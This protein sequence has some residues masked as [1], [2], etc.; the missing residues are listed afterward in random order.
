MLKVGKYYF[1]WILVILVLAAC[2]AQLYNK[3]DPSPTNF[4]MSKE[5]A[6][7]HKNSLEWWY[8]TG[9]LADSSQGKTFGME[10]VLFHFSPTRFKSY[11]MVNLAL[12]DPESPAFYY[13]H[14]L[15]PLKKKWKSHYPLNIGFD[16]LDFNLKGAEG[17][18]KLRAE[19][20]DHIVQYNLETSPSKDLLFH[21]STAYLHYGDVAVAGYFTYPRLSTKGTIILKNE[22][23]Q[24]KGDLWFDRQWN[25]NEVTD[26]R[27]AWDWFSVQFDQDSSELMIYRLYHK[28]DSTIEILGGTYFDK[29]N[30]AIVLKKE[31]I[32]L[33][34]KEQWFSHLSKR[35]YPSKWT[36]G[37][38]ALDLK[39]DIVPVFNEQELELKFFKLKKFYYWEGM[40]LATGTK[41]E[42]EISGKSYVEITNR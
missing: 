27:M 23:Y 38:K 40:C 34:E 32:S 24:V 37:V 41:G 1:I 28:E 15:I 22:I 5:E 11:A 21:D 30:Q 18:Y 16:Q 4:V 29:N 35:S 20:D 31:D 25:C 2:Q 42:Q 9:H 10:Y 13:D 6:S 26:Q 33:E 36:I 19:M 3:N 7:H 8:F 14:K 12:S 17:K 39:L